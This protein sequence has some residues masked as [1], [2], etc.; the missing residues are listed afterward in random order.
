MI[1]LNFLVRVKWRFA[2][3]KQGLKIIFFKEGIKLVNG[4]AVID[5]AKCDGICMPAGPNGAIQPVD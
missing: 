4:K 5:S 2:R 3:S 1:L